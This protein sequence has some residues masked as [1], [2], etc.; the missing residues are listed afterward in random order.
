[1]HTALFGHWRLHPTMMVTLCRQPTLAIDSDQ[2]PRDGSLRLLQ[3]RADDEA[4]ALPHLL[5]AQQ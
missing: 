3:P 5:A 4:G 1:M 2:P